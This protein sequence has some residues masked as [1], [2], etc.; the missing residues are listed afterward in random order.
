MMLEQP[1]RVVTELPAERAI[2][3]DLAIQRLVG[4]VHVAGRRGLEAEGNVSHTAVPVSFLLPA[5]LPSF[6]GSV[7]A[8]G[9][10]DDFG[11]LMDVEIPLRNGRPSPRTAG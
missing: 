1:G 6:A 4:L 8:T 9:S 2:L 11:R 7:R 3:H 10:P 5:M